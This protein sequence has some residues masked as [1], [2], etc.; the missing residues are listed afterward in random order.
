MKKQIRI[1]VVGIRHPTDISR[2]ILEAIKERE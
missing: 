1:V 2:K